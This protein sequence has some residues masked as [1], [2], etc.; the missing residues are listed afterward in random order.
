[1]SVRSRSSTLILLA[2]V[3][4]IASPGGVWCFDPIEAKPGTVVRWAAE[5]TESCREGDREWS[6]HGDTCYFAL[7]L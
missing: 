2:L 4:G 3:A 6:P 7:D 1:M 5:G